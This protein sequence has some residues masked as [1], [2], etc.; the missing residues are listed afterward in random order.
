MDNLFVT[1]LFLCPSLFIA[2]V[3][4][5]IAGGGG[6]ISLPSYIMTG[7][8][9]NIAYGC[10]KFQSGIGTGTALFKYA[11]SGY[12]DFKAGIICAV[13]AL[14]MAHLST[15]VMLQLNDTV[16]KIIIVVAMIFIISLMLLTNKRTSGTNTSVTLSKK[17]VCF[18]LLIG[19]ILGIY[20]GFFG[21][22]CGTIAL[23]LFTYFFR[24]DMRVASGTGKVAIT[25]TNLVALASYIGTGNIMYQIAIPAT[26]SNMI[27]GYVGAILAVKNGKKIVKKFMI[28]VVIIVL[29]QA[30]MKLI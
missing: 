15:L 25:I 27:G 17:N 9:L 5:A 21:P 6:I 22:G 8:P 7:V 4:D 11:R 2:G 24:Y 26:I 20:D 30:G 10:N 19:F 12:V 3:I 1:L 16:K 23:M 18:S 14:I 29:I 28:A 13:P